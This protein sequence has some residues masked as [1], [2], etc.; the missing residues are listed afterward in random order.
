MLPL[1]TKI[2]TY[3]IVLKLGRVGWRERRR[4]KEKE[5]GDGGGKLRRRSDE[6]P[7]L[8]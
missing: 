2:N 8:I 5:E 6:F 4:E 7:K 1:Y 3:D